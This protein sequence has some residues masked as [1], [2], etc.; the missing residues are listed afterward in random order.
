L[1]T[2]LKNVGVLR[3]KKTNFAREITLYKIEERK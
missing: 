3:A 2:F 1:A